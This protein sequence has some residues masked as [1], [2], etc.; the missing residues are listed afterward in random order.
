MNFEVFTMIVSYGTLL[1]W[2]YY[3]NDELSTFFEVIAYILAIASISCLS[4]CVYVNFKIQPIEVENT[5][6]T[7]CNCPHC[8]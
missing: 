1:L 2:F 6:L 7:C 3:V 5:L 4:V 8:R